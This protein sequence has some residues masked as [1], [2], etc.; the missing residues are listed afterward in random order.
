MQ[1]ESCLDPEV[2]AVLGAGARAAAQLPPLPAKASPEDERAHNETLG[3]PDAAG[4][5]VMAQ[6]LE[7]WVAARGRRI[8][9][10][11][12]RPIDQSGLPVA[13]YF[14]GGGWYFS[15]VDT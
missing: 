4:G 14:H 8:F 15:S 12:H 3:L 5:P 1:H 10:R 2:R 6:T 11:L 13:V 7:R 9:C